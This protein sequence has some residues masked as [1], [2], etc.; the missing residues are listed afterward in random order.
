M[1]PIPA[2]RWRKSSQEA[3]LAWVATDVARDWTPADWKAA[4]RLLRLVNDEARA[5]DAG[6]RQRLSTSIRTLERDLGLLR[7]KAPRIED[8]RAR[9]RRRRRFVD[10]HSDPRPWTPDDRR[11]AE[12]AFDEAAGNEAQAESMLRWDDA[13]R[14]RHEQHVEEQRTRAYDG[15]KAMRDPRLA[16]LA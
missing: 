16:L 1:E 8:E 12:L 2:G 7:K 4:E 11:A 10:A 13:A 3:W 9:R 6:E 15:S 14:E 5:S